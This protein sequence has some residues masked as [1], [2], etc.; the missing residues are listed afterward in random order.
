LECNVDL[1][2][3]LDV[4]YGFC[5]WWLAKQQETTTTTTTAN[6]IIVGWRTTVVSKVVNGRAKR[7]FPKKI[8]LV[9]LG[10]K[11]NDCVSSK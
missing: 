8:I 4:N 6:D 1:D 7:R 3:I 10:S 5:G 9:T 2:S 11:C